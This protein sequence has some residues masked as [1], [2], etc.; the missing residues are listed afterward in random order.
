MTD[1]SFI[2]R[3]V[4][5]ALERF[6]HELKRRCEPFDFE[7]EACRFMLYQDA[8]ITP[9]VD[10]VTGELYSM[11]IKRPREEVGEQPPS[12]R[13]NVIKSADQ[14]NSSNINYFSESQYYKSP[15]TA[16]NKS[17]NSSNPPQNKRIVKARRVLGSQ[18]N[19]LS[20]SQQPQQQVSKL[21]YSQKGDPFHQQQQQK[22]RVFTPRQNNQLQSNGNKPNF[23][24][25]QQQQQ[26]QL[27]TQKV[28]P[29][30]RA[31][32]M[33]GGNSKYQPFQRNEGSNFGS[34]PNRIPIYENNR[35]RFKGNRQSYN[36]NGY[37]TTYKP[38][39]QG[40]NQNYRQNFQRPFSQSQRPNY[41]N[42]KNQNRN[43]R[44]HPRGDKNS[45]TR[46]YDDKFID[47]TTTFDGSDTVVTTFTS[48]NIFR[49][50]FLG[51]VL[52]R[53]KIYKFSLWAFKEN[54][55]STNYS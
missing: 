15:P 51:F 17:N 22:S 12:K 9:S 32:P 8:N 40:G 39:Y 5:I 47:T 23:T 20:S 25:Q 29:Q 33:G 50:T 28:Q 21:P 7:T 31:P 1:E 38:N 14:G 49:F 26:F 27:P 54:Y 48:G 44:K 10:D 52:I 55:Q 42:N 35:N 6:E 19:G 16:T 24:G 3:N 36:S 41:N 43:N 2:P 30:Y 13:A 37:N 18:Q 4:Q 11:Q 53:I 34:N 46:V 45:Y